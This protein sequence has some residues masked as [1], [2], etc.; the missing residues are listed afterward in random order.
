M[1]MTDDLERISGE[2][3]RLRSSSDAERVHARADALLVEALE[4]LAGN[5]QRR[6]VINRILN[7]Y[8]E[9]EKWYA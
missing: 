5:G 4:T 8:D 2:M 7:N 1:T 3:F 9:I 6:A